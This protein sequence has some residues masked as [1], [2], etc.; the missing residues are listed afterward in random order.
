MDHVGGDGAAIEI[1]RL[2]RS[3]GN[4]GQGTFP[5]QR[6]WY[7]CNFRSVVGTFLEGLRMGF[8]YGGLLG[9]IILVAD[10]WAIVKIIQGGG[11]TGS[12]VLWIVL[13]LILPVLGLLL[14][15]LFGRRGGF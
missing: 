10:I 1:A 4:A 13:I 12:K 7:A 2:W 6:G 5:R 3:D 15:L 11:S 14:W 8:E 9:L